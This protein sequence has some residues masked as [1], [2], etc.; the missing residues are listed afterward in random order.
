MIEGMTSGC[1]N[2]CDQSE[3]LRKTIGFRP[4]RRQLMGWVASEAA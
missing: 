1:G 3:R 2:G 4:C